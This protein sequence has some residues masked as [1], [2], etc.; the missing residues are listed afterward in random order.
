MQNGFMT[1]VYAI[2]ISWITDSSLHG[3]SLSIT[4][5]DLGSRR[6]RSSNREMAFNIHNAHQ[7]HRDR[8]ASGF[9]LVS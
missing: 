7:H 4:A 9:L 1:T 5:D 3:S 6:K 2:F 8:S